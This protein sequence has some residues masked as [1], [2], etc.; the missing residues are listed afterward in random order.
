MT[1]EA[2]QAYNILSAFV[3]VD[4]FSNDGKVCVKPGHVNYK[5]FQYNGGQCMF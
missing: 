4:I 1:Y 5:Q 2:F 3:M